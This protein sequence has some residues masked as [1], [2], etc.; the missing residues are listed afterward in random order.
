M[1]FLATAMNAVC[2]T[3]EPVVTRLHWSEFWLA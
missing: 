1:A 3:N 2:S